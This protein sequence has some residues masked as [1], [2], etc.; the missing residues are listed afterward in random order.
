MRKFIKR[1]QDEIC[2][3]LRGFDRIRFRGTIRWFGSVRGVMSFLWDLQILL[4]EF[5][6]WAQGLTKQV[7]L[8]SEGIAESAG[9]R[10]EYL[11][12]STLRKETRAL[13]IAAADEIQ[14]G[15]IGVF[16]CVEP[17]YTFKVGPNAQTKKLELRQVWSKCAHYYFYV[18]HPELGLIHLRLQSWLP[19]TIHV[20]INGRE[21]LARQLLDAGI[22]FEQRDNCFVDVADFSKAQQFLDQQLTTDWAALLDG[23]RQTYHPAHSALFQ[24]PPLEFYW[25][26]EETEFATDVVFRSSEALARIY[27]GLVRHAITA[28]GSGDVLRFLGRHPNVNRYRAGEI[29]TTTTKRP[30]GIC[31]KHR[32]NNNGLKMYDKQ[33]NNLRLECTVN[34]PRDMKVFRSKEGDPKGPKSWQRLRKGVSDLHRRT[35]VSRKATERYLDALASVNCEQPLGEMVRQLCEPAQNQNGRVRALRPLNKDDSQ[36]LAAVNRGEFQINGFRNRDLRP[37]LFGTAEVTPEERK[38]QAAKITRLLRILRGHGLIQKVSKTHR[39]L[40]TPT[41]SEQINALLIAQQASP[42]QLAR[43]AA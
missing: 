32:F 7:V 43:L 8:A 18:L 4:T 36:L 33:G 15:L 42:E 35:Q 34:D 37:L 39:Y 13:E 28:F 29:V 20:C 11:Y 38:R 12:S 26:A 25:S 2:G 3:V 17:C 21:W 5:K 6:S 41:G 30:E 9:R 16:K 14:E 10:L 22:D 31:V 40:L 24:K 27:P 19:F 23:L 1:H